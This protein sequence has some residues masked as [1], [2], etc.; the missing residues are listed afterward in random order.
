MFNSITIW[1]KQNWQHWYITVIT[2]VII[3]IYIIGSSRHIKTLG[4]KTAGFQV[5]MDFFFITSHSQLWRLQRII[6]SYLRAYWMQS[7][8][9]KENL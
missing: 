8:T 6:D 7:L 2:Y 1:Q 3:S 9:H 4:S 5:L